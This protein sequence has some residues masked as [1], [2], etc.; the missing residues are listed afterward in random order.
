[1]AKEVQVYFSSSGKKAD[2]PFIIPNRVCRNLWHIWD[3]Y[4]TPDDDVHEIVFHFDYKERAP[5]QITLVDSGLGGDKFESNLKFEGQIT[6]VYDKYN[7][8]KNEAQGLKMRN[9]KLTIQSTSR[10]Q[11]LLSQKDLIPVAVCQL[12]NR[13][14]H[15]YTERRIP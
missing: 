10:S 1:M 3:R 5:Y 7:E 15:M 8:C 4:C 6:D 13:T 9:G 12:T 2:K 14:G 11:F